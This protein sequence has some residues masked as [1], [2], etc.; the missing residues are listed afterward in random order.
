MDDCFD[1]EY[2]DQVGEPDDGGGGALIGTD[3]DNSDHLTDGELEF[4]NLGV[5][6]RGAVEWSTQFGRT[7][8]RLDNSKICRFTTCLSFVAKRD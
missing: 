2:Q 1:E 4:S 7:G 5:C 8:D 6:V 3:D